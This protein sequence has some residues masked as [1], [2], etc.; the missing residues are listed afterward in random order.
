MDALPCPLA[1]ARRL[2]VG[3]R[4]DR[5]LGSNGASTLEIAS[6]RPPQR[7]V[8]WLNRIVSGIW[9]CAISSAI[10][11]GNTGF[12]LTGVRGSITLNRGIETV[13]VQ[14]QVRTALEFGNVAAI[15]AEAGATIDTRPPSLELRGVIYTLGLKTAETRVFISKKDGFSATLTY[16][17]VIFHASFEVNA[18]QRSGK[19]YITG[20]GLA[21]IVL[22]AGTFGSACFNLGFKKYCASLP[23][24]DLW[25]PKAYAEF[26][27]FSSGAFGFK[28]SIG[29][30]SF[31]TGFYID[32][33]GNASVG[34]VDQYQ[35]AT[36]AQLQELRAIYVA[37]A[38]GESVTASAELESLA[39]FAPNGDLLL[40]VSIVESVMA[41]DAEVPFTVTTRSD[42]IFAIAQ[43]L[44]GTLTLALI[45]PAGNT[46]IPSNLPDGIIYE[47]N[48]TGE[49]IQLNYIVPMAMPGVWQMRIVGD[50][51][52]DKFAYLVMRNTPPPILSGVSMA[53]T[54]NPDQVNVNWGVQSAAQAVVNIYANPG[55]LTETLTSPQPDGP[56]TTEVVDRFVG[57]P[58]LTQQNTTLN[59]SKNSKT[60]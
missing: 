13:N 11:I 2:H 6:L 16:D 35:L 39:T 1:R 15:Q 54:A 55:P 8:L 21:A 59:G 45:D 7:I 51:D 30:N 3:S 32:G 9:D 52:P 18:W 60:R 34:N 22:R 46:I 50:T 37:Q 20:T 41:A 33:N 25:G 57:V 44:T 43:P 27:T 28:G 36:H 12:Y 42:F 26:G 56:V 49:L 24:S 40:N 5:A 19:T 29:W 23:P 31:R 38:R 47:Q 4:R 48:R 14:I 10:P 53:T 17:Y 58:L